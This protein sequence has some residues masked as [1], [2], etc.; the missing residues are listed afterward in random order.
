[1]DCPLRDS[2]QT[3]ACCHLTL[4]VLVPKLCLLLYTSASEPLL[5]PRRIQSGQLLVP[6][7]LSC[8]WEDLGGLGKV[9]TRP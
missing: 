1:M 2:P 4:Q 3:Q 7:R 8:E 9:R 6:S 5:W